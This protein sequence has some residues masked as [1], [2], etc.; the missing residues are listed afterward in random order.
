MPKPTHTLRLIFLKYHLPLTCFLS[1]NLFSEILQSNPSVLLRIFISKYLSLSSSFLSTFWLHTTPQVLEQLFLI[2][3][4]LFFFYICKKP[5]DL[6]EFSDLSHDSSR[7]IY[8][9]SGPE[10]FKIR[11]P[12]C[13]NSQA[14][15]RFRL[16]YAFKNQGLLS[17]CKCVPPDVVMD[18]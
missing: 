17:Q 13:F 10:I 12:P 3:I 11:Y 7:S 6:L 2:L 15:S 8:L 9:H 4:I 18:G 16:P 1:L 5:C 14:A